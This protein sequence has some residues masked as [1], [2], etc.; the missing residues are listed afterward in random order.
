MWSKQQSRQCFDVHSV[1]CQVKH[2]IQLLVHLATVP[3]EIGEGI[4]QS[5]QAPAGCNIVQCGG[6]LSIE[7]RAVDMK[8]VGIP[9]LRYRQAHRGMQRCNVEMGS[10][11]SS[12]WLKPKK[13]DVCAVPWMNT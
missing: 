9:E 6:I 7:N 5:A 11:D 10:R 4:M 1:V 12:L 2:R 8:D 13:Y 3:L